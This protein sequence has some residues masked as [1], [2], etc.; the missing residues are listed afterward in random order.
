MCATVYRVPIPPTPVPPTQESAVVPASDPLG[1]EA[2][3]YY[4]RIP[5]GS[6]FGPA[7]AHV[8]R[9]WVDQGR[10]NASC[11]VRSA[12]QS[13]WIPFAEWMSAQSL[14]AAGSH[15]NISSGGNSF[16]SIPSTADQSVLYPKSAQGMAVLILG[17]TSWFLCLSW[18][19]T[20]PVALIAIAIGRGDL[21]RIANGETSPKDRWMTILGLW[22]AGSA[23]CVNLLAIALVILTTILRV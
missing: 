3:L 16:G 17:C 10:L 11:W 13:Q 4:V 7:P 22:L 20:I 9:Q 6:E 18:I 12:S 14:A 15:P 23:L 1:V 5:I 19:G 8:L 21:R 2:A